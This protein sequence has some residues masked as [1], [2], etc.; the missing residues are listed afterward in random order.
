MESVDICSTI[1]CKKL[2]DEDFKSCEVCGT[3][4]CLSCFEN[5]FHNTIICSQCGVRSCLNCMAKCF[6]DYSHAPYPDECYLEEELCRNCT[7]KC[8]ECGVHICPRH[9]YE[10]MCCKHKKKP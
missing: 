7:V 1:S 8:K 5:L 6:E 9:V 10:G 2:P 3:R 4:Y